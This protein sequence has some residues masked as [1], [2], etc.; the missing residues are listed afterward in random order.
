MPPLT[1]ILLTYFGLWRKLH[2]VVQNPIVLNDNARSYTSAAVQTSCPA[3]NGG[4]WNIRRTHPMS[5]CDYD[6]FVKV[7]EPLRGTRYNTRD[8]LIH[9]IGLSIRN[10]NK[11]RRA[12]SVRRLPNIWQKLINKGSDCIEGI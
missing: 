10:I 4:F 7:K 11:D 1:R 5:P 12:D 9:A 8:E 6:L 2:L 3:G